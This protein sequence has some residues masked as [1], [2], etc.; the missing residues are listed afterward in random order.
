MS[1]IYRIVRKALLVVIFMLM[2]GCLDT[3]PESISGV[4][5][6]LPNIS[7]VEGDIATFQA[8][9]NK[10]LGATYLWDFGDGLG[11]SGETVN[12]VYMDEGLYSVIL[13]V[14][15]DGGN[16]GIAEEQMEILHRNEAPIASVES[17]YGGFGQSIKVNSIAFFDGGSSSDPDGDVLTFEWDFGDGTTGTGIRPN[18]LYEKIGNFT[19]VLTVSDDGELSSVAQTWVLVSIRTYSVEFKLNQAT[20][21]LLAGYTSESATSTET[22]VYPYNLTNVNYN[23]QWEEDETSDNFPL[24]LLDPLDYPDNFTLQVTQLTYGINS[25]QMGTTGDLSLS[26]L[27]LS[28]SPANFIISF[29]SVAEVND[30]LFVEG[31]TSAKG[32]GS[33]ETAITCN[34]AP[35]ATDGGF[36]TPAD[37]DNGND[38]ILSVVY[39][40]YTA[41]IV[42][43]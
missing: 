25:S 2:P 24:M 33:W 16:I 9:G 14:I 4:A 31:Y 30:Y 36:N 41:N 26:F 6:E 29:G 5:I 19:V 7:V 15:D 11:G 10:P 21:P 23:L 39:E 8:T 20:I 34:S 43:L 22:H 37:T 13:T 42:E 27:G 12:H 40:Y 1:S 18:H 17:T 28:T 35:S 32:E 38:W 3:T